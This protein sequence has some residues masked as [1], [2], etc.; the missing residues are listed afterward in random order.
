MR[1]V[2]F[3]LCREFHE[4]PKMILRGIYC[5]A[6]LLFSMLFRSSLLC[7][8]CFPRLRLLGLFLDIGI[9]VL[10]LFR[11]RR[12]GVSAPVSAVVIVAVA[13][14]AHPAGSLVDHLPKEL[15]TVRLMRCEI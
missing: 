2:R 12:V 13:E 4:D 8:L 15:S 5:L 14:V 7:G 9:F 6:N 3:Q 10:S 1:S 11:V